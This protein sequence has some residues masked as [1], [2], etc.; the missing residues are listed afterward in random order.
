MFLTSL[1]FLILHIFKLPFFRNV[2]YLTI[3]SL[4]TTQNI[5]SGVSPYIHE[6]IGFMAE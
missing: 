6:G 1:I 3:L 4:T 5:N 2:S